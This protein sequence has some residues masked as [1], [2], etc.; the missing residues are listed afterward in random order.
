[1]NLRQREVKS[2]KLKVFSRKLFLQISE[3]DPYIY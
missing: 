1:M 3:E 2:E